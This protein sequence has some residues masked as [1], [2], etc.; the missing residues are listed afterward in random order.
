MF[1]WKSKWSAIPDIGGQNIEG[2]S[3]ETKIG[4][5]TLAWEDEYTTAILRKAHSD[6]VAFEN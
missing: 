3:R 6:R 5:D 2:P 1:I 4:E